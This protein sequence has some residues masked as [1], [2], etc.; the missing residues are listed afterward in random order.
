MVFSSYQSWF[1]KYLFLTC[2]LQEKLCCGPTQPCRHQYA[3][4]PHSY[5][6]RTLSC[7]EF[8]YQMPCIH[9]F[10]ESCTIVWKVYIIIVKYM[11][12]KLVGFCLRNTKERSIAYRQ[13]FR[14]TFPKA[15]SVCYRHLK[16]GKVC[17]KTI[18][19]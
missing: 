3:L 13:M 17:F 16:K 11:Y 6:P 4:E 12:C 14:Y 19:R 1:I 7:F 15:K 18:K 2:L 8:Q 9:N 10:Q 5:Q